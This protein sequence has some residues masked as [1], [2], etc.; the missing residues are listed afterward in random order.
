VLP[1]NDGHLRARW[2]DA[3]SVERIEPLVEK[4]APV[5][6]SRITCPGRS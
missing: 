1:P 5:T 2:I 6:V 4:S 3:E